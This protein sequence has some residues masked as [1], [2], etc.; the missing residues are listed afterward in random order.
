V[1]GAYRLG[2][3]FGT[4]NTVAA[5]AGP[6]GRVR[7]LLFDGSPLLPSAVYADPAMGLLV[8]AD[9]V[10]AAV[11]TPARFEGNPKRRVD[12]GTVWLGD[13]EY[14]VADLIAA[15]LRRVGAEASR[16]AGG[17]VAD[18]VLTHPAAWGR[19]RLAVLTAAAERAGLGTV[20]FVPEPVAAAAY[21]AT[22]LG[23]SIPAGRVIVVYDLGAGTFD[24]SV[25][26]PSP[27]GFD[28][29]ATDGLPDVGGVDLDAAVVGHVRTL[30]ASAT[31]AWQRLDWPQNPADQ[32]ARQTLWHGARAVKEQLSRH[33]TG[34]LH[35]P[36][37]DQ[38]IHLTREEFEKA[39]HGQLDRTAA[40]TRT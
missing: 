10:R 25:V 38:R 29:V 21:F 35:V 22:V 13:R 18:V 9:A 17:P 3:D 27:D 23:R 32:Q 39:A 40:L 34:E 37:V 19:A 2:I 8:G 16:V 31:T 4:S 33:P 24:V 30:T 12:E 26:R 36:L 14:P 11:G 28:V 20:R 7:P 15:V 1:N 5:L 6:D